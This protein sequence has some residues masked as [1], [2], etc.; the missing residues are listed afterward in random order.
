MEA[1]RAATGMLEVLAT[2]AV[3]FMIELKRKVIT[4][5]NKLSV[6]WTMMKLN[7]LRCDTLNLH[8]ELGEITKYFRHFV[9]TLSTS[10]VDDGIGVGILGQ[11]LR[12]DSLSATEGT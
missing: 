5:H 4:L 9:S 7:N 3:R 1:S 11:R 12:D 10:D 8:G 6:P 2:R